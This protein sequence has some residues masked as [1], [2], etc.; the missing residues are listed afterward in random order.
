MN[1]SDALKIAEDLG[2]KRF[3]DLRASKSIASA[4]RSAA[5]P[6]ESLSGIYMHIRP[7]DL[8]YI[9]KAGNFVTRHAQHVS[10]K[11]PIDFLAFSPCPPPRMLDEERVFI[12]RAEHFG[13]PVINRIK[14]ASRTA[15]DPRADFD[16]FVAPHDQRLFIEAAENL[17]NSRE[18]EL[19]AV[20][21]AAQPGEL[22][23]W[24]R[25]Q[26]HLCADEMIE[27]AARFIGTAVPF[28]LLTERL[29]WS[30]ITAP[31]NDQNGKN[32]LLSVMTGL[33]TACELFA[34]SQTKDAVFAAI[35]L[36]SPTLHAQSRKFTKLLE[37]YHWAYWTMTQDYKPITADELMTAEPFGKPYGSPQAL[38]EDMSRETTAAVMRDHVRVMVPLSCV[39]MILNEPLLAKAA[40]VQAIAGMRASAAMTADMHNSIAAR[41]CLGRIGMLNGWRLL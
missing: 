31:F 28:P 35:A 10:Q 22:E 2:F 17:Q 15:V 18:A 9:G 24:R 23:A 16:D 30:V 29:Y 37:R 5:P 38:L 6:F 36:A 11:H 8:F 25:L 19:Q 12:E 33:S 27:A 7:D 14:T 4:V 41:A 3:F 34:F 1:K 20:I 13:L 21:A 40:A 26:Q 32:S 39:H